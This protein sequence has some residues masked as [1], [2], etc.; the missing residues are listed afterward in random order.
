MNW[1]KATCDRIDM[2]FMVKR[3]SGRWEV[4]DLRRGWSLCEGEGRAPTVLVSDLKA[5]G[6]FL[7]G[8]LLWKH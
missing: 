3:Q 2:S 5:A 1:E 8:L 7:L 6:R 4:L